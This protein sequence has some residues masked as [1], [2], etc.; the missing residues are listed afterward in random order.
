[1]C[2]NEQLFTILILIMSAVVFPAIPI[3]II[4]VYMTKRQASLI[5]K[6][7]DHV[8]EMRNSIFKV[9]K[10]QQLIFQEFRSAVNRLNERIHDL[11]SAM[12]KE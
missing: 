3:V 7:F 2:M 8:D 10:K 1:M 6:L 12:G 9:E 4:S 11:K 5:S